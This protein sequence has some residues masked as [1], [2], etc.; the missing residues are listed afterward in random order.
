MSSL[1][2]FFGIWVGL[3][4]TTPPENFPHGLPFAQA[5]VQ[6]VGGLPQFAGNGWRIMYGIGTFLALIGV[7][8]R[9][10]LP[11]SPRWLIARGRTTEAEQIVR[12]MEHRALRHLPSL[13]PVAPEIPISLGQKNATYWEV[14]GN[15]VYLRRTIVLF[16]MW[17]MAFITVYGIAV[18]VTTVLAS[19]GYPAPEA[20]M[21]AAVGVL[22][23]VGVAVFDYLFGEVLERKHW[24]P[25]AA[26]VT[27]LGGLIIALGGA[28]NFAVSALGAIILF[29][30][31]NMWVPMAYTWT[32]ESYPTRARAT[33]F[34]LVDG[35]GHVGGG[36]G[37]LVVAPLIPTLGPVFTFLVF[38]GCLAVAAIIAQFGTPTRRCRAGSPMIRAG[39][40]YRRH[41]RTTSRARGRVRPSLRSRP[42]TASA[43]WPVS[44]FPWTRSRRRGSHR[45]RMRRGPRLLP[46]T[47]MSSF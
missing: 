40:R 26:A 39:R 11:E 3:W 16:C 46:R 19:L 31:F 36:V 23:F 42:I 2:A 45:S 25:V 4:L 18:G 43:R 34:A 1:G 13:P 15:P 24:L 17:F 37:I 8:L 12:E 28:G 9:I 41:P 6:M 14:L 33:G 27:L 21:I 20:G 7:V 38:T 44:F 22:G 29:I 5:T 32:T 30:G 47:R 35:V 10:R